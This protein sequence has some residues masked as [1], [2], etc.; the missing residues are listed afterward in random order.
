MAYKLSKSDAKEKDDHAKK[1][2]QLREKLDEAFTVAE[3]E[4]QAAVDRLNDVIREYNEACLAA[5]DFVDTAASG[6][7][8]LWE[9][10]SDKWQESETGQAVDTF[11]QTWEAFVGNMDD[12]PVAEISDVDLDNP[13]DSYADD[14]DQLPSEAEV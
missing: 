1:L 12:E 6:W 14:L 10:K 5:R 9:A 4:M 2:R 7:K 11:I 3:N 8:E 13:G